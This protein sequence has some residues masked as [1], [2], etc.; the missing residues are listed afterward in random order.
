MSFINE[1][2]KAARKKSQLKQQEIA[3]K[4]GIPR[5]TYA[6]W[7][8][9]ADPDFEMIKRIAM[10]CGYKFADLIDEEFITH[11]Q[12]NEPEPKYKKYNAV[13]V[14]DKD[15]LSVMDSLQMKSML[16]VMLRSQA[17]ILATQQRI[18]VNSVLKKMTD[19]VRAETSEE[20]DEL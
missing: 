6:T 3:D 19:A 5:S 9:K 2:I 14:V 4:L 11:N 12:L 7:E 8:G 10:L 18:P 20:F 16:R 13:K 15:E 17:E 1:N